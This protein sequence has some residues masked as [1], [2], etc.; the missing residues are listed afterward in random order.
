MRGHGL[1]VHACVTRGAVVRRAAAVD[2]RRSDCVRTQVRAQWKISDE[3]GGD[4]R[5]CQL[6]PG[7]SVA[8]TMFQPC[9][10]HKQL[11]HYLPRHPSLT[12]RISYPPCCLRSPPPAPNALLPVCSWPPDTADWYCSRGVPFVMGTTGGDRVRL[13]ADVER[14]G[15]YAVI[16]PQMGKQV[17]ERGGGGGVRE[18]KG[19]VRAVGERERM[20]GQSLLELRGSWMHWPVCHECEGWGPRSE[21]DA[22]VFSRRLFV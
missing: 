5:T 1:S 19:G 3:R 20:N 14:A 10:C 16:A 11:C 7:E 13:L 6:P 21:V 18:R 22:C 8:L 12:V 4:A 9:R 17:R 2:A 15:V